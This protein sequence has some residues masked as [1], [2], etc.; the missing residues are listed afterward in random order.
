MGN[1]LLNEVFEANLNES[2]KPSPDADMDQ[3]RDFT[4]D[5]YINRKF[6]DH[7]IDPSM[8]YQALLESVEMRDIRQLLQ[9]YAEG[10]DLRTQLLDNGYN[11][12]HL[13]IEQEDLTSLHLVDFILSNG[14]NEN[15]VDLGGNTPLHIAALTDNPQCIK[16]L[17]NHNSNVNLS[18]SCDVCSVHLLV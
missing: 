16:L 13:V 3:R 5:K 1:S 18:E 12:L 8:L 7:Q 4:T 11:A 10:A 14:R 9:V 17:L 15:E 2:L 6:I